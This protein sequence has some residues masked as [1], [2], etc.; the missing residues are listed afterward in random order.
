MLN[1]KSLEFIN[2]I[3]KKIKFFEEIIPDSFD[4]CVNQTVNI[5]VIDAP[6]FSRISFS[7]TKLF[8]T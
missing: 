6:E 8:S 1:F 3:L 7:D 5:S 2:S 4:Y